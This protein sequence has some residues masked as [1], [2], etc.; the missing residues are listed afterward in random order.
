MSETALREAYAEFYAG[1]P[2]V[3]VLPAGFVATNRNVRLSNYCDISVHLPDDGGTAVA[4]AAI[5]NMV[6]GSAGEAIQC[7]N[8][9]LGLDEKAGI[10]M[11]PPAF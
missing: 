2:F 3:R 1:E 5:D 6:K 7:M 4:V 9:A 10:S 8:I 11:L